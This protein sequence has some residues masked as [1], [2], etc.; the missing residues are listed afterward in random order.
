MIIS[1]HLEVVVQY[2]DLFWFLQGFCVCLFV[3]NRSGGKLKKRSN[4][5]RLFFWPWGILPAEFGPQ[6]F[7]F[8]LLSSLSS[9]AWM[10]KSSFC[11]WRDKQGGRDRERSASI[12]EMGWKTGSVEKYVRKDRWRGKEESWKELLKL[13]SASFLHLLFCLD[14]FCL[15][16]RNV[17]CLRQ[18]QFHS[19]YLCILNW[20]KIEEMGEI[21]PK[22]QTR[23]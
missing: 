9:C 10:T 15:L 13:G 12:L 4:L 14:D 5:P 6:E 18:W 21:T 17:L 2:G 11:T 1:Y 8:V 7:C 22:S 3:T 16:K 23:D 20:E 19:V